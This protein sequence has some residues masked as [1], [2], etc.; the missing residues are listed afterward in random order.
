M[1]CIKVYANGPN[2]DYIE[3]TRTNLTTALGGEHDAYTD[4]A[5]RSNPDYTELYSGNIGNRTLTPGLYKWSNTV[6]IPLNM[7]ISGSSTDVFIFQIA[8]D[9]TMAANKS[10][11]LSGARAENIFWQVAGQ[12]T[13]G[14]GSHFEGIILSKTSITLGTLASVDGRLFAQTRVNLDNNT[15]VAP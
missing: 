11:I 15:I 2:P 3:P 14:D 10:I 9:I 8:G 7:T 6:T 1:P 12:V 13:I 4:A 5:G